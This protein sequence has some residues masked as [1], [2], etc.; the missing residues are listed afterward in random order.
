MLEL[1][2]A[3]LEP[4]VRFLPLVLDKLIKLLVWSPSILGQQG[5][6]SQ[7]AFEALGLLVRK[8]T[9]SMF[10]YPKIETGLGSN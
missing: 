7:V 9:V 1:S 4:L 3:R 6:M 2:N 5:N 10:I 8:V